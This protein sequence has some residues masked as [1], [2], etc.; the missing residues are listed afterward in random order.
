MQSQRKK[1]FVTGATRGI[2][3]G[4]A[5]HLASQ[6]F[7]LIITYRS[8]AADVELVQNS[9]REFGAEVIGYHCDLANPEDVEQ[10]AQQVLDDHGVPYGLVTC[11]GISADG[12]SF[13][14]DLQQ[15]QQAFQVNVFS[16]MQLVSKFI[17][18]MGRLD[19]SR[20]VFV[21]S[22][23]SKL[24][25]RGNAVYSATKGAMQSY[26]R[27]IIEEFARRGVTI[28]TV[29]PGFIDTEMTQGRDG[30]KETILKRIPAHRLGTVEDVA[31]MI[32]FLFTDQAGFINGAELTVDG[33][34]SATLGLN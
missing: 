13:Q 20:I 12:L 28:N 11:A 9:C 27:S 6:G 18:P 21:S 34:M 33:G 8:S 29:L 17:M 26:M 23:S 16:S 3:N 2:G 22:V 14:L 19:Q 25:N 1:V 32:G 10:I 31:A 4:V 7:D 30:W 15:A 24:G 5:R